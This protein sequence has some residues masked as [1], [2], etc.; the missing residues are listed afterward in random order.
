MLCVLYNPFFE[1]NQLFHRVHLKRQA[2]N[3][4]DQSCYTLCPTPYSHF[5]TENLI[6]YL[7]N[8]KITLRRNASASVCVKNM[9]KQLL[10]QCT[11]ASYVQH[12]IKRRTHNTA[13][14][15]TSS[16]T[17]QKMIVEVTPNFQQSTII[18]Q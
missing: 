17:K 18:Q 8:M 11:S 6:Q 2:Q 10:S 7:I 14:V 1:M 13:R 5:C 4:I 9:D 12:C 16:T 15:R 3:S